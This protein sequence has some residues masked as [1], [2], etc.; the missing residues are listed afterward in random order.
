LTS[1][2][3]CHFIAEVSS[4][5]GRD[6]NRCLEF[7]DSACLAGFDSVKYQVFQ[8]SKLFAPEVVDCREDIRRRAK[9][10]LPLEFIPAISER[11]KERGLKFGVTP[12]FLEAVEFC[13]PYVDYFKIASYEL[14]WR[15][16][17]EECCRIGKPI[18][19]STGMATLNELDAVAKTIESEGFEDWTLLH[20]VSNYPC[21]MADVNLAAISTLRE[22]Y[23]CSIGWSDH[24]KIEA[25]IVNA[26]LTWN[27]SVV[28]MHFDLDGDGAEFGAGHCWLPDESKAVIDLCRSRSICSG[29]GEKK[30]SESEL[31]ERSWRADPVDGLR[32]LLETRGELLDKK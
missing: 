6:L 23:K 28:E 30:P 16:L 9:W 5:H 19:S 17:L 4:N 22:R 2:L 25:V 3:D 18:V 12:F 21:Q 32:P 14:L 31:F 13:A 26:V 11:C 7:V 20:C 27:A 15:D 1:Q 24:S 8:I 10:E 29:N